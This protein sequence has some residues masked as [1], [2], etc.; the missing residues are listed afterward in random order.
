MSQFWHYITQ[1]DPV[2]YWGIGLVLLFPVLMLLLNEGSYLLSKKDASLQS[3]LQTI[4]NFILPLLALAILLSQVLEYDRNSLPIKV[5]ET[6]ILVLFI[7]SGLSLFT[8]LFLKEGNYKIFSGTVPQLFLDI[9]RV[10]MVVFGGAIVLSTVWDVELGGLVTAL[11]LGSFVIGLALQD[12][13]GNLFSGISLVYERPFS[14]GDYIQV[15]DLKGKVIEMNWRA[16]HVQ[17]RQNE[18]LVMPH[19]MVAQASILNFSQPTKTHIIQAEIGFSYND[20]P[21]TVKEALMQT[22]LNTPGILAEPLPE[23]KTMSYQDSQILYEL[24]F[25]IADYKMY[26]EITDELMTRLYYTA[27]RNHFTIPFPQRTIHYAERS[28]TPLSQNEKLLEKNISKL[29]DY[30][31]IEPE[32]AQNLKDGSRMAH[33]G[34]N[35]VVFAQGDLSGS[36]YILTKGEV[37][38]YAKDKTGQDTLINSLQ[39]GDYFGEVALLAKRK[40]SMTAKAETDIEVMVISQD[41]VME[42]VSDSPGFAFKLGEVI[43]QRKKALRKQMGVDIS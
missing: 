41:E 16:V 40:S 27:K 33:Y 14:V 1:L 29:P 35:E 25:G 39:E 28:T 30:Y 22:C 34:K 11:G 20:A 12:T 23:V 32:K 6:I 38:L 19:L 10:L 26:E 7:N 21:N 31:P 42:M 37:N 13:L 9:F 5:L 4:K 43:E 17:T 36:I 2:Y 8:G 3:P 24:E 15:N 18:L